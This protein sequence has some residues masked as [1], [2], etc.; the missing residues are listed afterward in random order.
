MKFRKE[1]SLE[2]IKEIN[3]PADNEDFVLVWRESSVEI[4]ERI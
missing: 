2:N 1:I 3:F 4:Y